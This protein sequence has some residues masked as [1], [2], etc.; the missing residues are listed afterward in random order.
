MKRAKHSLIHSYL[1]SM[2]L[3]AILPVTLVGYLWIADARQS[4]Q[5]SAALWQQSHMQKYRAELSQQVASVLSYIEFRQSQMQQ[6]LRQGLRYRVEEAMVIADAL[7]QSGA[8][9]ASVLSALRKLQLQAQ[10]GYYTV[11]SPEGSILLG[12]K[13]P[14]LEQRSLLQL[15]Q[16]E[17]RLA[18]QNALAEV[19]AKGEVYL[20][21]HGVS[22]QRPNTDLLL[23]FAQ[24]HPQ[25]N[26]VIV[27]HNALSVIAQ[28]VRAEVLQRFG[29]NNSIADT[30]IFILDKDAQLLVRP[31]SLQDYDQVT[32]TEAG[33]SLPL[34]ELWQQLFGLA[35]PDSAQPS[36]RFL[37]YQLQ[38]AQ[39]AAVVP[40][41]SYV[42]SHPEWQW[43]VGAQIL[44]ADYYQELALQQQ[45]FDK[46]IQRSII[47]IVAVI[48]LF[49]MLVSAIAYSFYRVNERGFKRFIQFFN[50]SGEQAE[51]IAVED[52]PYKEFV[53]LAH[54]A[55]HMLAQRKSYEQDLRRSKRRFRLALKASNS[56]LWEL[57]VSKQWLKF[58]GK[59]LT[60]LGYQQL[61]GQE[62]IGVEQLLDICHPDDK[63]IVADGL[64]THN[65]QLAAAGIE[66][67]I[68]HA[69][70][71]YHWFHSRGGV[72]GERLAGEAGFLAGIVTDIGD[73]KCLES[74][75]QRAHVEVEEACHVREQFLAS[76][77]HELHTPLN[78][79]LGHLQLLQR[80]PEM[81]DE[82]RRQLQSAEQAGNYLLRLVND[83][84]ELS[85]ID[86]GYMP[87]QVGEYCLVELVQGVVDKMTSKASAKGLALVLD[88]DASLPQKVALD[89]FKLK[90]I[91]MNLL[92]NAIKYTQCG[93]VR[94]SVTLAEPLPQCS[95]PS[96]RF[97]ISDTGIGID[98]C[99][100]QEIFKPFTQLG[101]ANARGTGLGLPICWRLS[102]ALGGELSVAS[103]LGQG[104]CFSLSLPLHAVGADVVGEYDSQQLAAPSLAPPALTG[105]AAEQYEQLRWA[106]NRGDI[107]RL[108]E[109]FQH[110]AE[111]GFGDS[112]WLLYCRQQLSDFDLKGL[113]DFLNGQLSEN[114]R[115]GALT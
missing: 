4:F 3:V 61:P 107:E 16:G 7:Y 34:V 59:F 58:T 8:D 97:A 65:P 80:D 71:G 43:V 72:I 35:Q 19:V 32:V 17:E 90:Q 94:L 38:G 22:E 37:T 112:D 47:F 15:Y 57:D 99:M 66:F 78:N 6:L 63:A 9:Q 87:V 40:A 73:R 55:N 96:L 85:K 79:I 36:Q 24:Y 98:E 11:L 88:V 93:Q 52:L 10:H 114:N 50:R 115:Q 84:L 23:A 91:L 75:L 5:Q 111:S 105:L 101:G 74:D 29:N 70:G 13:R 56:Y 108:R 62:S 18:L 68:K 12:Q 104:S 20:T 42:R 92:S 60:K 69:Q 33:P 49:L 1:V 76:M 2:L 113:L 102:Q 51:A 110:L 14:H 106:A 30:S 48:A 83:I 100:A 67:R 109:L 26:I 77:S 86:S 95:G 82:Q 81:N 44:L 64:V 53:E 21:I 27:N 45:S 89:G 54:H 28:Q 25:L 41:M 39:S 31:D 103:S 46:K